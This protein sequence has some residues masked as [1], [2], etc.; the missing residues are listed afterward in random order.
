MDEE[1]KLKIKLIKKLA[2]KARK[3][4]R[5]EKHFVYTHD[6]KIYILMFSYRLGL[7]ERKDPEKSSGIILEEKERLYR[8]E[9]IKPLTKLDGVIKNLENILSDDPDYDKF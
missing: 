2:N 6:E 5:F 1:I 4:L 3:K 9:I 7:D 8:R